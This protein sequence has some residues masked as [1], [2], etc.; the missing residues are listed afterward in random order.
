MS[1]TP[2]LDYLLSSAFHSYGPQG[3]SC[4]DCPF[5]LTGPMDR[6]LR[7]PFD[8]NEWGGFNGNTDRSEA[9][10]KCGLLDRTVWGEYPPCEMHD[11]QKAAE[12]ELGRG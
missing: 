10:Y 12:K 1:D 8:Q 7:I 4:E 2:A 5:A 9:Y 6:D 11:W 3:Y